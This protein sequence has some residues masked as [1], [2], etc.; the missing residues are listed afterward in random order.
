MAVALIEPKNCGKISRRRR[1][2]LGLGRQTIA[3]GRLLHLPRC[4]LR[5]PGT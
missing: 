2:L 5:H 4:R 1:G 3:H